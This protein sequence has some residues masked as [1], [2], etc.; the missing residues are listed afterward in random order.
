NFDF[1]DD[2]TPYTLPY[3]DEPGLEIELSNAVYPEGK[4]KLLLTRTK[5]FGQKYEFKKQLDEYYQ[6]TYKGRQ[7]VGLE[8]TYREQ[9]YIARVGNVKLN[10]ESFKIGLYDANS[11]G[12]YTDADTDKVIFVNANDTVVDA[13]N[14]LNFVVFSK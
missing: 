3:F 5:L 12:L 10:E 2:T 4:I 13:T 1:T 8:F 7:F 6:M 11:N 14:P 9:R